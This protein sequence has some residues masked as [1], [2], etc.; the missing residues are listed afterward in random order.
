[1]VVKLE[2]DTAFVGKKFVYIFLGII[3]GLN[4]ITFSWLLFFSNL[5]A[6]L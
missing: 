6:T 1:M 2:P 5:K 3:F 4:A